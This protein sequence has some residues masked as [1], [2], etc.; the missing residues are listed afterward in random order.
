MLH[1]MMM[2]VGR[3]ASFVHLHQKFD[4]LDITNDDLD[5]VELRGTLYIELV[6]TKTEMLSTWKAELDPQTLSAISK[7]ESSVLCISRAIGY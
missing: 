3:S 5:P 4:G 2:Y 6:L 7:V 1:W